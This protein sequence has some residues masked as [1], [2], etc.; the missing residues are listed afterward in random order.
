MKL[1]QRGN[2][3]RNRGVDLEDTIWLTTRSQNDVLC[4]QVTKYAIV[5]L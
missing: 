5:A 1:K 3:N 4:S 2:R